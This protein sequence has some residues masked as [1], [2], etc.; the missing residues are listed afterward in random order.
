MTVIFRPFPFEA[1]NV[2]ALATSFEALFLVYLMVK[3]WRRLLAI[4]AT[5]RRA[6]YI[7]YCLGITFTFVYAFSSFS[8]FGI[9]ARQRCQVMPFFL[10]L[11]CLNEVKRRERIPIP[12]ELDALATEPED[13]YARF[14][15][16]TEGAGGPETG[17]DT[18]SG[19]KAGQGSGDPG[20][21]DHG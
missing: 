3:G 7:A 1:H 9:L 14:P 15:E 12:T 10:A 8:N 17:A 11:I 13:P 6:S 21:P 4:P 2:Q 5:A 16:P 20:R 19:S 18:G